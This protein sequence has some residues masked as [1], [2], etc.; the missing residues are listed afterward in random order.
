MIVSI[1]V[2]LF[3]AYLVAITSPSG[4]NTESIIAPELSIMARREVWKEREIV[5]IFQVI[6]T[7]QS[8]SRGLGQRY[9]LE[10]VRR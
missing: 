4:R 5:F 6:S 3:S 9:N 10:T 1:C 2:F 8:W 7:V